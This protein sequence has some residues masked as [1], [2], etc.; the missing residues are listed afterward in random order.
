MKSTINDLDAYYE[1]NGLPKPA[2]PV[3]AFAGDHPIGV[4]IV[5]GTHTTVEARV[6]WYWR[7]RLAEP[8]TEWHGPYSTSEAA[9]DGFHDFMG[10][11]RMDK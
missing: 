3:N 6:G 5:F 7:S 9:Y 8:V 4:T 11:V 10:W 1:V 2:K